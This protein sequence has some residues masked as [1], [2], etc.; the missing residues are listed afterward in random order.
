MIYRYAH[1]E[2]FENWEKPD[3]KNLKRP[4]VLWGAGKVGGV[5]AH[6]MKKRGIHYEAFCDIARDKQ[7]TRFCGHEVISPE[8]LKTRYPNAAVIIT[9][10][11]YTDTLK[12][13]Q[14]LGYQEVY[15]CSSLFMEID[16]SD[17]DFWTSQEYAIRNVE[18]CLAGTLEQRTASGVIDQISLNITTK[19]SLRCRECSVFTPY[20]SAP[21]HYPAEDIMT[22]LNKVLDSLQ[23]VR[24]VNFYGGEPL[25]HPELAGMI[26][27]LKQENRIDRI[28][29]ISNGTIL[30]AEN[31]LQ[32]MEEEDRFLVR[33]S[34]YGALSRK[35]P[36]I[37]EALDRHG[38]R[39][40][41]T[42]YSYW[43]RRSAIHVTGE[44]EEE[45]AAKFRRC[46]SCNILMLLNRKGY[47]CATSSAG[48]NMG[49]FPEHPSNYIDLLDDDHFSEKLK[50]FVTRPGRG[51]YLDAC[52]YCSG[53]H[54]VQFEQKVP[55]AEQT[56][57]LLTFPKLT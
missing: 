4:L 46:T 30:P 37:T 32:A 40:E 13:L 56:K 57:E 31:V 41:V 36:E 48:C 44:T 47:L 20:I 6:C 8:E 17:Y 14:A 33:L 12:M 52:K 16:F 21:C 29:I 35:L 38:I 7:G 55:V 54:C 3:F 5:A 28:S 15:D 11:F 26:Q 10:V 27:S 1:P 18:Q 2:D 34:N 39:Y 50:H 53:M 24:I 9:S 22:D 51:E 25:L 19:C 42:N 43:D 23:H 49:G 45:L